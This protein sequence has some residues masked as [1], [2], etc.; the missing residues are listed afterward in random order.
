M[1]VRF[2]PSV[3]VLAVVLWL[4]A[5]LPAA[6]QFVSGMDDLPLMP[7]LTPVPSAGMVFDAPT[8]R[9]VEAVALLDTDSGM[10]PKDVRAFYDKT[11][12][13]LGW[14][15]LQSGRYRREGE[16]LALDFPADPPPAVRFRLTPAG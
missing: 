10:T 8:G 9:I 2:R 15:I 4:V 14:R 1:R 3:P 11:L 16:I 7:G 12:P 5:V 13:Q 6:A